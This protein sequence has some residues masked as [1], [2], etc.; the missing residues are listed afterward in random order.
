MRIMD[1]GELRFKAIKALLTCSS[2]QDAFTFKLA[3]TSQ[4]EEDPT[5]ED[6]Q[7]LFKQSFT[8]WVL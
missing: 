6:L 3:V 2:E 5:E 8:S 7:L 1:Q 4:A